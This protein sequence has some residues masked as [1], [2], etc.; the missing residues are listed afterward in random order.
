MCVC[1][2]NF[3]RKSQVIEHKQG[4]KGKII[5]SIRDASGKTEL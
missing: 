4:T 3:P 5:L 2:L 1:V